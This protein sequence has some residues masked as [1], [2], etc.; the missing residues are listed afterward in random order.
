MIDYA[1]LN[2][3]AKMAF[4]CAL[5]ITS[6][7]GE[8]GCKV[9]L[10]ALTEGIFDCCVNLLVSTGFKYLKGTAQYDAFCRSIQDVR[11]YDI[12]IEKLSEILTEETVEA[13]VQA[14]IENGIRNIYKNEK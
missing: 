12:V 11:N 8:K 3:K 5:R 13:F 2:N 9:E 4:D 10:N 1:S 6:S 7:V 14:L